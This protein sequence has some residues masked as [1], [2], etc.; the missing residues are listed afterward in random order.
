MKPSQLFVSLM[1]ALAIAGPAGAAIL[2]GTS[3]PGAT[4]TD[5]SAASLVSFDLDLRNFSQTR[6]DYVLE[7]A[8]LLSP[9]LNLNAIVR[10]LSGAGLQHFT[11]A[12][13]G[14]AL[15]SQGSVTPTFGTLGAVGYS[16]HAAS[17]DFAS[18]E[19]AEF[20]FGNP[21]AL[22]GTSDWTLDTT[23]MRAGDAFSITATV[24]EPSTLALLLASLAMFSFTA[25]KRGKR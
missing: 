5:F 18:P 7:E 9:F 24:P 16:S 11:F 14:I 2:T 8:D 1:A 23:G 25:V 15:A 10:N 22:G 3:A 12:A 21:F 4:V 17:I 6:L 13:D 19:W 20:H